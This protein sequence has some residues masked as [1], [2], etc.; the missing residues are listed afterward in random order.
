M[1]ANATSKKPNQARNPRKNRFET[2][3]EKREINRGH[4][5]RIAYQQPNASAWNQGAVN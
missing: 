4:R 3:P 1:T 5:Q 2:G